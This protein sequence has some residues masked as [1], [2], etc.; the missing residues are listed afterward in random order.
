MRK[1][2]FALS[3]SLVATGFA[4]AQ[5]K[6]VDVEKSTIRWVGKKITGQHEGFINLKSGELEMEENKITGG[7][8]VVDMESLYCT[9]LEGE[10]KGNLEGHLK[11]D[12]FFGVEKYPEASFK[13]T[14]IKA[15]ENG[16]YEVTGKLTVKGTTNTQTLVLSMKEGKTVGNMVI[17]RTDFNVRYGSGKF[18]S[19][20]GDRT[21]DDN[22]QL[23]ITLIF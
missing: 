9:D 19:N 12:D 11:S 16:D 8:F 7:Y 10:S 18:F 6:T 3:F 23:I 20:L 17:D 5:T 22:F 21:I 1:T 15:N 4:F 14:E 13:F 2:I